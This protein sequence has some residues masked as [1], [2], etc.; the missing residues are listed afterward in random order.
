M[1]TFAAILA[2]VYVHTN[3]PD[4][5]AETT[6]AVKAATL[7]AHRADFYTKDLYETGISFPTSEYIQ[8]L[9]YKNILPRWRGLKYIRKYD[10]VGLTAGKELTP[11][12]VEKVLDGY[13]VERTD[14]IYLAGAVYNIK[15]STQ[16]QY[17][18]LG[19]YLHPVTDPTTYSSWIADEFPNAIVFDAANIV[20]RDIH[21]TERAAD[22]ANL[23]KAEYVEIAMSNIETV[24]S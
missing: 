6:L 19:A 24:G 1:T 15:S 9:D 3:R 7:R 4:L 17:Y 23:A 14:I 20:L 16:E 11:V 12:S 10:S 13:N 5:V 8:A 21:Q 2:D 22:M 18:L